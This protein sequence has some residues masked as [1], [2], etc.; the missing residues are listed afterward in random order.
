MILCLLQVVAER[1][2]TELIIKSS[3][4]VKVETPEKPKGIPTQRPPQ[5]PVQS[6]HRRGENVTISHGPA[7]TVSQ[8]EVKTVKVTQ[9]VTHPEVKLIENVGAARDMYG[10]QMSLQCSY[11]KQQFGS[12]SARERHDGVCVKRRLVILARAREQVNFF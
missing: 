6:L 10:R 8:Y 5:P 2:C 3:P 7:V 9:V 1:S 12:L 4:A 11:C